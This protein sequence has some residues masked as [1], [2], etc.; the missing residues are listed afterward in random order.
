VVVEQRWLWRSRWWYSRLHLGLETGVMGCKL[1]AV[2]V[3][4]SLITV[5]SVVSE[6]MSV[7]RVSQ[8]AVSHLAA[9]TV[10]RLEVP[11]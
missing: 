8:V 4:Q 6:T 5:M 9:R 11:P 1:A 10:G 7:V 2:P 3:K